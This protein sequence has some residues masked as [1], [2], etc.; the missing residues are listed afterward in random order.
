MNEKA[1]VSM[2][3]AFHFLERKQNLVKSESKYGNKL[4]MAVKGR[5]QAMTT[6][7]KRVFP[8]N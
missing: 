7:G 8:K 1:C 3:F 4:Q 5:Q 2:V 6:T